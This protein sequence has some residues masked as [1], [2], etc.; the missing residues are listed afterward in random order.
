MTRAKALLMVEKKDVLKW[1]NHTRFTPAK[2]YSSKYCLFHRERGHDTEK[3]YQLKDEIERLVRQG[4]FKNQ[5]SKNYHPGD[6]HSRSRSQERR[7]GNMA[8]GSQKTQEYAPVKG[9]IH[10]IAGGSIAGYSRRL[11][12]K[13]ERK[14][15]FLENRQIM[16]IARLGYHIWSS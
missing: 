14:Y 8:V 13:F 9:I 5:I 2:K 16:S 4:Y 6:R 1:P 15:N 12:K 7:P 10:T 3:C 11:R